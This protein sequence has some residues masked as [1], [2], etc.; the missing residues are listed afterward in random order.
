MQTWYRS[1]PYGLYPRGNATS[2]DE[3]FTRFGSLSIFVT[4]ASADDKEQTEQP[5]LELM[6]E[7]FSFLEV[8]DL[9]RLSRSCTGFYVLIHSTDSFK[10]AYTT[11][12][13]SY[14]RFRG[15]WKETALRAYLGS[16]SGGAASGSR[17]AVKRQRREASSAE[18]STET[19]Q[20]TRFEEISVTPH[21]PVCVKRHFYCDNLFQAWMCTILPSHYHLHPVAGVSNP[22][23][24][25]MEQADAPLR[26]S[27]KSRGAAWPRDTNCTVGRKGP[28]P[29]YSSLLRPVERCSRISIDDFRSRFED[30]NI[31]CVITDVATE[32]PLFRILNGQFENLAAKKEHLVRSGCSPDTPLRCEHTTMSLEDYVHYAKEQCDERPIYLFDAEF[33]SLLD[34]EHLYTVPPHFARDDFLSVLGAS[35]PKYR[36]II[37]GP[38]R[39][40]SSFHIDP[41]YTNAWNANMT[42]R[43]RWLLFPPGATPPGVVPSNDMSQVATP[44]SL[45]E[46]LLNFYDASVDQLK[47]CGYEC[48]CE[49]G[50][51]MFVPC[52][53]WHYVINLEDSIAITQ[54]YVSRCNLPK[55]IK[56]LRSMKGSIS[57]IDEDADD[58]DEQTTAHRQDRFAMEFVAAM[59][60]CH[61]ELMTEVEEQLVEEQR[62]REQRRIGRIPLLESSS[63][64]FEFS[65]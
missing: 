42:G 53:W 44:V 65:F 58:A 57:G 29:S 38:E 9:C 30:P 19:T 23:A 31:P 62:Q 33:G 28:S 47:H 34:I 51:I 43:K 1:N 50:D 17:T 15:S 55:V 2:R 12:S 5:Y 24:T 48:I 3:I 60:K 39:G 41:N 18:S 20:L 61:P 46:W 64:G 11:I 54:N 7:L 21:I 14:L 22:S 10:A 59:E 36:W 45:T 16:R 25:S 56:F 6:Q 35:R 27:K 37:A 40:G 4:A 63:S 8:P 32:W 26:T 52:G 49:P 13:P